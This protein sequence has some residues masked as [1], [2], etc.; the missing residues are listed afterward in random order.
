MFNALV[1]NQEH[2]KTVATIQAL[3]PSALPEANTLVAINHSSLNY[4]DGLAITGKGKII[5]NF[6]M[7]PGIDFVGTVLSSSSNDYPEGKEVILTGW[8]VG[9]THWGGMAQQARVDAS[10]LVPLPENLSPARA[11]MIGTAGL[12]AM[13]CVQALLDGG[14]TPESGT[15]LVTG[16]SGGV[17]SISV[18]LLTELG[19]TVAACTGRANQ[20]TELLK[21]LGASEI[22]E[23]EALEAPAKPLE[24]QV[25]AGVIDS[26]GSKILAKALAQTQYGGVVAACGL[27]GGFDL[28]TTVMPFILRNI[29]LKGI[30]SVMCP[31]EK[32]VHAW[33]K[34]SSL[35][36]NSFYEKASTTISL[37]QVPEFAEKITNGQVTG[38]IIVEL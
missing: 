35:L 20:N 36:P 21:E 10:W 31:K 32:R 14:L 33:N 23:R 1:L 30:D 4:K 27:A 17:G 5:R 29:Q 38:R 3:E 26:V 6:P 9:E 7:I 16:A 34:I 12:T 22:I 11:M 18:T 13:L 19:F 15:I 37:D 24:K 28:P 25:W 2:K 8:G